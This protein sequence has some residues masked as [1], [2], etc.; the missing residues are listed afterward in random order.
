M[1]HLPTHNNVPDALR[2]GDD[3]CRQ[4][5][6]SC[7][8]R[9]GPTA[10]PRV[11]SG[12]NSRPA[13]LW[14]R[15]CTSA[16]LFEKPTTMA[17]HARPLESGMRRVH[18]SDLTWHNLVSPARLSH[19]IPWYAHTCC[20]SRQHALTLP[21]PSSACPAYFSCATPDCGA[22]KET[23]CGAG[24]LMAS[25][26]LRRTRFSP[27]RDCPSLRSIA[28]L[29]FSWAALWNGTTHRASLRSLCSPALSRRHH[30]QLQWRSQ[31]G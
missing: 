2:G 21:R 27:G 25:R 28:A 16:T 14:I 12:T 31:D 7:W 11:F 29:A 8:R 3:S 23:I 30:R 10:K 5:L 15:S 4:R 13:L 22:C 20:T 24:T 19:R 26:S 18:L 9:H 6:P 17:G 1:R